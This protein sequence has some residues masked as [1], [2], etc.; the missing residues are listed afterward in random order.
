MTRRLTILAR[1]VAMTIAVIGVPHVARGQASP[2][3]AGSSQTDPWRFTASVGPW[4]ARNAIIIGASGAST[5]LGGGA[6]FTA[7]V[8]YDVARRVAIYAGGLAAF[9]QVSPGASLRSDIAGASDR[10]TVMGATGGLLLSVPGGLLGRLEPTIRLG[11]GMKGYRFDLG[12]DANQWRPMGDFGFGL[13]GGPGGPLDIHV[14]ARYLAST[15]DQAKLPTRGIVPQV[16]R[17]G[18]LLLTVGVSL[19]P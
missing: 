12:S 1:A 13:R 18:D 8:S 6:A 2:P 5:T 3:A 19:R 16:Q 11:G 14:E 17:Q 9:S 7:D 4:A 10:V 15:I